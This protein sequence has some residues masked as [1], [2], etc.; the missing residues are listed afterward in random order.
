MKRINTNCL[1]IETRVFKYKREIKKSV[2][3]K[4]DLMEEGKT[5]TAGK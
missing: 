4:A 3:K 2:K 5:E 1:L